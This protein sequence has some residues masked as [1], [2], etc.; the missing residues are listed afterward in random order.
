MS[1]LLVIALVAMAIGAVGDGFR[2]T[3]RILTSILREITRGNRDYGRRDRNDRRSGGR[4]QPNPRSQMLI[5]GIICIVIGAF[6]AIGTLVS[7]DA[8]AAL[9][10][11]VMLA[12]GLP[13][14]VVVLYK[15]LNLKPPLYAWVL[16][17]GIAVSPFGLLAWYGAIIAGE[18]IVAGLLLLW[19]DR[20]DRILD[21]FG[22]TDTNTAQEHYSRLRR[23]TFI[24]IGLAITVALTIIGANWFWLWLIVAGVAAAYFMV[25]KIRA[26][27]QAKAEAAAER[28]AEVERILNTKIPGLDVDA[29][30]EELLRKYSQEVQVEAA[31]ISLRKGERRALQS[32]EIKVRLTGA[33]P[34]G[35]VDCYVFL[36]DKRSRV[37]NDD[38]LVFFGQPSSPDGSVRVVDGNTGPGANIKLSRVPQSTDRIEVVYALGEDAPPRATWTGGTVSIQDGGDLFAYPVDADGKTRTINVLRLYRHNKEWKIWITD[39]RSIRGIG[40]LCADY[41]VDVA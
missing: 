32:D 5:G 3:R 27:R 4:A 41:G 13:L 30:D 26:M 40:A 19:F 22:E 12:I 39:Y 11:T 9:F 8:G 31:Q 21:T 28:E 37:Q 18:I 14:L 1:S 15:N 25:R 7:R 34:G 23:T 20:K 36:L 33:A 6:G 24:M 38:D 16:A 29:H 35:D 10:S 17:F 2:G